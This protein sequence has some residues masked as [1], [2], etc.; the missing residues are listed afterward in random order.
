[1]AYPEDTEILNLIFDKKTKNRGF[2]LLVKKYQKPIYWHL[3]RMV[4]Y[5]ED[6]DDLV[7]EVF[8][9]IWKNI[10][11]FRKDSKLFT[12]IYRIATNEALSFLN[13]KKKKKTLSLSDNNGAWADNLKDDR[14]FSG[15]EIEMRFQKALS[16]LPNKQKLVFNMKY[17]DELKYQEMS[18]ILNT[19]VGALKASYH[20]AVKK[21]EE[22]LRQH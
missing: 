1:M 10:K 15:D 6:T 22:Q 11:G 17:Y 18:E 3:R 21:I 19:S 4:F 13:K 5:H 2:E 14:Y 20:I 7:Q 16:R 8:I 9:K 12:W